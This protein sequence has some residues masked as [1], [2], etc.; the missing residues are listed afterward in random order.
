MNM[1]SFYEL[2]ADSCAK[3]DKSAASPAKQFNKGESILTRWAVATA[4]RL[5]IQ[6]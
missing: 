1:G 5:Q 2:T 3:G 6:V 4:L